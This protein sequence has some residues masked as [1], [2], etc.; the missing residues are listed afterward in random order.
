MPTVFITLFSCNAPLIQYRG[1][2]RKYSRS[3]LILL[4]I[5]LK[6]YCS[7]LMLLFNVAETFSSTV[8]LT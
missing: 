6:S 5:L 1:I 8:T 4:H 3:A 2:I 7:F